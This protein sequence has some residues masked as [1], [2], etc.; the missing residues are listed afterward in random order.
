MVSSFLLIV[1][2]LFLALVVTGTVVALRRQRCAPGLPTT[3]D[4]EFSRRADELL[5][6]FRKRII[7]GLALG[8]VVTVLLIPLFGVGYDWR[9]LARATT[10]T[11]FHLN[12]YLFSRET[13]SI[14]GGMVATIAFVGWRRNMWIQRTPTVRTATLAIRHTRFH[15]AGLGPAFVASALL[16]VLITASW[17]V[18]PTSSSTSFEP[19][20]GLTIMNVQASATFAGWLLTAQTSGALVALALFIAL[21]I[22]RISRAAGPLE[23]GLQNLNDGLRRAL[24]RWVLLCAIAA[25]T[26][27][28]GSLGL[29]MGMNTFI[30]AHFSI[31]GPCQ[32]LT[33]IESMCADAGDWYSQPTFAVGI[34]QSGV[35][36]LLVAA[37]L[38]V[39]VC[40]TRFILRPVTIRV[41]RAQAHA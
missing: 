29:A 35:G 31:V 25:V 14:V 12:L 6:A 3:I 16:L 11:D 34:L 30:A 21:T 1:P 27:S 9:G 41:V 32:H 37:A 10:A 28:A 38:T 22:K 7:R 2:A 19:S 24:S 26:L 40:S 8:A 18:M 33:A 4:P 36:M 17:A 5:A 15:Q 13:F 23:A 39:I 20:A